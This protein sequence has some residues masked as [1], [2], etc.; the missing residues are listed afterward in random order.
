MSR[1]ELYRTYQLWG[2]TPKEGTTWKKERV[3]PQSKAEIA[4]LLEKV[5]LWPTGWWRSSASW[6]GPEMVHSQQAKTGIS[7]TMS[8]ED[9]QAKSPS[10]W[11]GAW[12]WWTRKCRQG[13]TSPNPPAGM[14]SNQHWHAHKCGTGLQAGNPPA[15]CQRA[16]NGR[17]EL[18]SKTRSRVSGAECHTLW[19]GSCVSSRNESAPD[20]RRKAF[21]PA[22]CR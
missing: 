18:A 17:P 11:P 6:P 5:W 14:P 1:T 9:W 16:E 13:L 10:G 2:N 7:E 19:G 15:A 20:S 3:G 22:V 12:D 8:K 21:P 4:I